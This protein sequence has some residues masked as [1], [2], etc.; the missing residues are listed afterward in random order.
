MRDAHE[1]AR[2]IASQSAI[3]TDAAHVCLGALCDC[4]R[5][6]NNKK[7]KRRGFR[8]K[9]KHKREERKANVDQLHNPYKPCRKTCSCT[10]NP[11]FHAERMQKEHL[12]RLHAS[13]TKL[14]IMSVVPA[15]PKSADSADRKQKEYYQEIDYTGSSMYG[16]ILKKKFKKMLL[17]KQEE[18][19]AHEMGNKVDELKIE[20]EKKNSA[21]AIAKIIQNSAGYPSPLIDKIS[22]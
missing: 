1:I 8:I 18:T 14:M 10:H 20:V 5:L 2:S 19:A 6:T 17:Q 12:D 21:D 13:A 11:L 3:D 16:E 15:R 4:H 22:V 7:L 9:S